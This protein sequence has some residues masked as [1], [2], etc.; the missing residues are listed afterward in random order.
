MSGDLNFPL[1]GPVLVFGGLL[2]SSGP[3]QA[4]KKAKKSTWG[5]WGGGGGQLYTRLG[6]RLQQLAPPMGSLCLISGSPPTPKKTGEVC[7]HVDPLSIPY[8]PLFLEYVLSF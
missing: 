6:R 1:P 4:Y 8:Y 3:Y 2:G 7:A 5:S